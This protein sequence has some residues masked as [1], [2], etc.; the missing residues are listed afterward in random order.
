MENGKMEAIKTDAQ[1]CIEELDNYNGDDAWN[2]VISHY[3]LDDEKQNEIDPEASY[4][5]FFSDGSAIRHD[6]MQWM[7]DESPDEDE[8]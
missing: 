4:H 7:I 6:G 2:D 8:E 1:E 3:L 5:V